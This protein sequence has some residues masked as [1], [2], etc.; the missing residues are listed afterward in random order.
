MIRWSSSRFQTNRFQTNLKAAV[1]HSIHGRLD[2]TNGVH[3]NAKLGAPDIPGL[4]APNLAENSISFGIISDK[5]ASIKL[6][7]KYICVDKSWNLI[8]P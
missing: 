1:S 7:L 8:I 4:L 2:T 5:G 6:L 3:L